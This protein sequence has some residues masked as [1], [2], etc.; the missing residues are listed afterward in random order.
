[1]IVDAYSHVIP[2][3][4][5]E[6]VQDSFPT[7]EASALNNSYLWD[8]EARLRY[9][10]KVGIDHQVLTL[11]RPPMWLGM[12]QPEQVRL[13][14]LANESLAAMAAEHPDRFTAVG[15]L[16]SVD[17]ELM[18]EY[19]YMRSELGLKGV[20]I[21]TNVDGKPLDDA[22]MWPLY[23]AAAGDNLPIWIHPQHGVSHDWVRGDRLER[24]FAWPYETSLA[25]GRLVSGG[26]I[27]RF[28][29]IKFITHHAGGDTAFFAGRIAGEDVDYDDSEEAAQRSIVDR[30]KV[31][32][33]YRAFYGDT[34]VN[35]WVP[36]LRCATEF[37]GADH[38]VFGTDFPMGPKSGELWPPEVLRSVYELGLPADQL[39][40]VLSGNIHRLLGT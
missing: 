20:L 33:Q 28:P 12:P 3:V 37:F 18:R 26:V 10:D 7:A 31:A 40:G 13:T 8:G 14:R 22:S 6:A 17:D 34:M 25:M 27:E 2:S 4:F 24:L 29:D 16:P 5:L 15:V 30:S 21:F 39:D 1:V 11:V 36:A 19:E 38:L 35:G 23:E 9:L 32:G